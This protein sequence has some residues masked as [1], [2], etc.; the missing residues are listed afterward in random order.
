MV[1]GLKTKLLISAGT[2]NQFTIE[3]VGSIDKRKNTTPINFTAKKTAKLMYIS[4]VKVLP[5]LK[6]F[7]IS[8][9]ILMIVYLTFNKSIE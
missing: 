7:F 2:A 4:F 8:S 3:N 6:D 1:Q 9:N 5:L